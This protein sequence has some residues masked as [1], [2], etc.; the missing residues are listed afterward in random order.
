MGHGG[1][2][3]TPITMK[4]IKHLSATPPLQAQIDGS[5]GTTLDPQAALHAN[6]AT[7]FFRLVSSPASSGG[8]N[9]RG[10]CLRRSGTRT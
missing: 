10:L 1:R 3:L 6:R 8:G 9:P 7:F 2:L 4:L 5:N